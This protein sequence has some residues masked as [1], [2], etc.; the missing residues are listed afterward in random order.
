MNVLVYV[1]IRYRKIFY[2]YQLQ[3]TITAFW[4]QYCLVITLSPPKLNVWRQNYQRMNEKLFVSKSFL[5]NEVAIEDAGI[6]PIRAL[7]SPRQ[8]K[9]AGVWPIRAL[10]PPHQQKRRAF[11]QSER[12]RQSPSSEFSTNHRALANWRRIFNQ[13]QSSRQSLLFGFFNMA[14]LKKIKT[15]KMLKKIAIR[16]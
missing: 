7:S 15:K 5:W 14:T 12:S 16:S 3:V 11:D 4:M 10:S 1:N 8:P 2:L 6:W 13:S 9:A